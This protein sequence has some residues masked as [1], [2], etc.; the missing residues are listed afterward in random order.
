MVFTDDHKL[1]QERKE[2]GTS[3]GAWPH[4]V[5]VTGPSYCWCKACFLREYMYVVVSSDTAGIGTF[6]SNPDIG[7]LRGGL[8]SRQT[9]GWQKGCNSLGPR[10]RLLKFA[11]VQSTVEH[12]L[13]SLP[14]FVESKFNANMHVAFCSQ[15]KN[16]R[17]RRN[18]LKTWHSS[19]ALCWIFC[20]FCLGLLGQ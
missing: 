7:Y 3:G 20:F 17:S 1:R 11:W 13:Q 6:L 8:W 18:R 19:S 5:G 14:V 2:R 4:L 16:Y 15:G 10:T 12:L 9:C